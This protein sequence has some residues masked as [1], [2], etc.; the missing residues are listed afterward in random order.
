MTKHW[1]APRFGGSEVLEYVDT[2]VPA[3]ASGEVTI[4]VR[5][6]GM[7]PA[8][9]KHTRQGDPADLPIAVG[10]EVAGVLSAVGPDTQI[11]S[12]G[13]A[14][15]DEVLAFRI[16]GG[17]AESVT[18]PAADVF[19]KPA[20]LGFPEAANLLLAGSTAADML[21]VTRA[22]GR[23]TVLVHGASGAV[24]SACS[25]SY[26]CSAPASSAPRRSVVRTSCDASVASGSRTATAWRRVSVISHPPASTWHWTASVPTRPSTSRSRW[27]RTGHG[28]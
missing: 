20:S 11:A 15:G 22:E 18:V 26:G 21:R 10:Y 5:A 7:N 14:V 1:A 19:A 2:E 17:W 4:A 16:S 24:A 28:S 27:S 25:S 12:G 9:T 3:P 6:A 23:D 13:G 8:D